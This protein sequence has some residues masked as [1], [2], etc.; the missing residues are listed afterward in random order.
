[1]RAAPPCGEHHALRL[2]IAPS[3]MLLTDSLLDNAGLS[4]SHC[5]EALTSAFEQLSDA[6]A[7]QLQHQALRPGTTM[8][9]LVLAQW[10]R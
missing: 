10:R 9:L 6:I 8:W 3:D 4:W 5:Y 7:L 1:M 2:L